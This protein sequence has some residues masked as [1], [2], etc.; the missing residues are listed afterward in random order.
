M[1]FSEQII[2]DIAGLLQKYHYIANSP[3]DEVLKGE[4]GAEL[5][6]RYNIEINGNIVV[7]QI[8][9]HDYKGGK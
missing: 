3:R 6:V 8:L 5:R 9:G 1:A 4:N 7:E 2:S